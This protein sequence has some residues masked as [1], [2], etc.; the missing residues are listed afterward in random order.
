MHNDSDAHKIAEIDAVLP[1][2]QCQLCAYAGCKPYAEAIVK[3]NERIDLCLPGGVSVLKKIGKICAVDTTPFENTLKKKTKPPMLAVIREKECIGCMKCIQACPVDA[4]MGAP[5]LMHTVFNTICNGCELCV[6][7]CPVDCIDMLV[8]PEKTESEKK[9]LA[10][11]SRMRYEAH[12]L[13]EKN[14]S[15]STDEMAAS[16]T[17]TEIKADIQAI[18]KRV[19]RQ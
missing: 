3:K 10:D 4:I 14:V 8:L 16:K 11:Q 15:I 1:Q 5:K 13:R 6:A 19:K 9:L 18:L 12:L 17:E 2:T 7:P